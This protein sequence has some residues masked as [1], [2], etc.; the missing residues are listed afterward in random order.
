M[1]MMVSLD[2]EVNGFDGGTGGGHAGKKICE[3]AIEDISEE[4]DV[5]KPFNHVRDKV[6]YQQRMRTLWAGG[7]EGGRL[8]DDN[9]QRF[10]NRN[11]ENYEE[12]RL[13]RP[14]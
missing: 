2:K 6:V 9:L 11:S 12:D 3:E 14:Y 7:Q 5:V 10:L 13:R 8:C 4:I 1:N